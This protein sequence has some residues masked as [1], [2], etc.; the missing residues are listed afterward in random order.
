[1]FKNIFNNKKLIISLMAFILAFFGFSMI[2]GLEPV[3]ALINTY[4]GQFSENVDSLSLNGIESVE[5]CYISGFLTYKFTLKFNSTTGMSN[6]FSFYNETQLPVSQ[7]NYFYFNHRTPNSFPT[8]FYNLNFSVRC[9]TSETA[10]RLV[11][12]GASKTFGNKTYYE[13]ILLCEYLTNTFE[14]IFSGLTFGGTYDNPI[15]NTPANSNYDYWHYFL[16]ND[17]ISDSLNRAIDFDSKTNYGFNFSSILNGT[18]GQR[19]NKDFINQFNYLYD[20]N[21]FRSSGFYTGNITGSGFYSNNIGFCRGNTSYINNNYLSQVNFH[22]MP[23]NVVFSVN[24]KSIDF[25]IY[26]YDFQIHRPT[27]RLFNNLVI[28]NFDYLGFLQNLDYLQYQLR[29]GENY[30]N[31]VYKGKVPNSYN[32]VLTASEIQNSIFDEY[33]YLYLANLNNPSSYSYTTTKTS[34][35]SCNLGFDFNFSQYLEPMIAT[36]GTY[37]FDFKKPEY[38]QMKF[39]LVPFYIPFME[40]LQNALIWLIFYC[41]IISDIMSIVHLNEFLGT[42]LNVTNLLFKYTLGNVLFGL[43]GFI[44]FFNIIKSFM[45]FAY[46]SGVDIYN[47]SNYGIYQNEQQKQKKQDSYIKYARKRDL[48]KV[49]RSIKRITK[50]NK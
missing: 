25:T 33:V 13:H 7:G 29:R 36:N 6:Y 2:N 50:K 42:I 23:K 43:I 28:Y 20:N 16:I 49:N 21:S 3:H 30:F 18:I 45:P 31:V 27:Y 35:I 5:Q 26:S 39:T 32:L 34:D 24:N 41:P 19:I 37:N 9:L 40:F 47:N 44:I 17:Y 11:P 8:L 10:L 15:L 12:T 46:N 48:K 38:V 1:M 14:F 22:Y 4:N